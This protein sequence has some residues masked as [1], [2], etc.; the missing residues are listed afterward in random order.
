[1]GKKRFARDSEVQRKRAATTNMMATLE[2]PTKKRWSQHDLTQIQPLTI[3]QRKLF[4]LYDDGF[5]IIAHGSAGTGKTFLALYLALSDIINPSPRY[6]TVKIVRTAVPTVNV[7]HLPGT[8]E[9]KMAV[10]ELPYMDICSELF[11][12]SSTYADMKKAGLIQFM[13]TSY[14]RGNNW[15]DTVVI[16]DEAQNMTWH[17]IN[18]IVTRLGTN[19]IVIFTGDILQT[20]ITKNSRNVS[21]MMRLMK[22]GERME[23]FGTV[24]FTRDDIVRSSLVKSWI[25]ASE[26]TE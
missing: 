18:T 3:N 15:N 9:E 13:S 6:E 11:G 1:M 17:E 20:D 2:G 23:E 4:D 22:T 19:S 21:G 8:L 25:I 14:I 26:H 7:G 24:Q 10:Y 16:V 12:R 5:N